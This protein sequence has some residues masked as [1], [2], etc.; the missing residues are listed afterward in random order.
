M[1][2]VKNAPFPFRTFGRKRFVHEPA[3]I[4]RFV[5]MRS[6]RVDQRRIAEHVDY[7]AGQI[8]VFIRYS[9]GKFRLFGKKE[10]L[11]KG[12]RYEPSEKCHEEPDISYGEKDDRCDDGEKL[13]REIP[14][15]RLDEIFHARAD[16]LYPPAELS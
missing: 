13:P 9:F 1:E 6:E 8:G 7:G 14:R 3:V 11:E 10:I 5:R 15:K 16:L 2:F 12:E 4:R